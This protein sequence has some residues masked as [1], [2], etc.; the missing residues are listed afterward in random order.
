M[1][2]ILQL[3]ISCILK[4]VSIRMLK[5]IESYNTFIIQESLIKGRSIVYTWE[6]DKLVKP[7]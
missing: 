2:I 7:H 4:N 3:P 6:R 1:C 5:N